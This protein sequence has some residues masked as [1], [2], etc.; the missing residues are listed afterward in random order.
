M[1]SVIPDN[2]ALKHQF[3]AVKFHDVSERTLP[4]GRKQT[5]DTPSPT[6]QL[7]TVKDAFEKHP[8]TV[9]R[10]ILASGEQ[11]TSLKI[12]SE[13]ILHC[14]T[15]TFNDHDD[16]SLVG[17]PVILSNFLPFV[18]RFKDIW[19]YTYDNQRTEEELQHLEK[20]LAFVCNELE[21]EI[22]IFRQVEESCEVSYNN[23]WASFVPGETV[24]AAQNDYTECYKVL[25]CSKGEESFSLRCMLTN[26]FRLSYP[27]RI[28]KSLPGHQYNYAAGFRGYRTITFNI[29]PFGGLMSIAKLPFVPLQV[30]P[31]AD[32][33]R[34]E[35]IEQGKLWWRVVGG[36]HCAYEGIAFVAKTKGSSRW[37]RSTVL[38][39]GFVSPF[40]LRNLRLLFTDTV[41]IG[42]KV[43]IDLQA[44]DEANPGFRPK[45]DVD[46]R[47]RQ[48]LAPPSEDIL[49]ESQ[50]RM[51]S[52]LTDEEA[53]LCPAT[54]SGFAFQAKA[55]AKFTV[56]GLK[57]IVWQKGLWK[58]LSMDEDRKQY[59]WELTRG[60]DWALN[61]PADQKDLGLKYLLHG[62]SGSG[63]SLTVGKYSCPNAKYKSNVLQRKPSR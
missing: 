59:I 21:D 27:L 16:V 35:C 25:A 29:S 49:D 6:D 34:S 48:A 1:A 17:K 30:T 24:V 54:A 20:L 5:F 56:R 51:D 61:V 4:S 14:L 57:P 31:D 7:K 12:R 23:L 32:R 47:I 3:E 63:K 26:L 11:R 38:E 8:L 43:M 44:F 46:T 41:K 39:H 13:H 28:T 22:R 36:L 50:A 15:Q 18:H 45:I 33:I 37:D 19:A 10:I 42:G 52:T 60:H 40:A 62:R 9:R 55:W 53:L 58:G 2:T